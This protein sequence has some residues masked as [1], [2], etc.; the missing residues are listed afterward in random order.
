MMPFLSV[1]HNES[2]YPKYSF[3]INE[4]L[5]KIKVPITIFHGTTDEEIPYKQSKKLKKE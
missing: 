3:P 4:Y 2:I 1:F 5:G